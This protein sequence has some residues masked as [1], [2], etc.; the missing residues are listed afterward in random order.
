MPST[1][2]QEMT[3][4]MSGDPTVRS[5]LLDGRS[6]GHGLINEPVRPGPEDLIWRRTFPGNLEQ[7]PQARR[8]VRF[9]LADTPFTDDAELIAS[10]LAGN[11]LAHSRS[12]APDGWFT[13]E[14][15]L[16]STARD[17]IAAPAV[18]ALI[19]VYDNGGRGTPTFLQHDQPAEDEEHG[20]GLATV[21]AL[22]SRV[23]FQGTPATG[24]RV[25][26]YLSSPIQTPRTDAH[27]PH[28]PFG[29]VR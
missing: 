1:P 21:A 22:A 4:R 19:T 2:D 25:W 13:V 9:L 29:A 11:A 24:H 3:T 10:E 23:G 27:R 7:A 20:R 17:K 14:V 18:H 16:N 15:T 8:F 28:A 5:D 12:G 6:S 26:A